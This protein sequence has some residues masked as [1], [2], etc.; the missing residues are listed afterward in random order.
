M[1]K[2][3]IIPDPRAIGIY[4]SGDIYERVKS[5]LFYSASEHISTEHEGYTCSDS[6]FDIGIMTVPEEG[7][8]FDYKRLMRVD[9]EPG[10]NL[11]EFRV[12]Q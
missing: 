12:V 3:K 7:D 8:P 5:L 6:S 2:S 9:V 11:S 1:Y 10:F 4:N